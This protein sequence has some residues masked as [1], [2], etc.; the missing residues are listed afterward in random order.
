LRVLPACLAFLWTGVAHDVAASEL[1]IDWNAP[2]ECPSKADMVSRVER[3]LSDA[4]AQAA[5]TATANV[6]RTSGTYR[7]T[8]RIQSTAGSGERTLEN[9]NCEILADSIALV[10][11]LS[12]ADTLA[13]QARRLTL[14]LSAH[15]TA[16][17][18]PLPSL[19]LGGGAGLALEGFWAL[20]VELSGTYYAPQSST[21]E[22]TVV[23]ASFD[24]LRFGARACRLWSAG[25]FDLAPCLGAQLYRIAGNGFGGVR[26]SNGSAYVWGPALGVFARLRLY[27]IVAAVLAADATLPVSRQTF[28][29]TDLGPLHRPAALA[30]QLFI[31]PE[32]RF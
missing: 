30:L 19:A 1:A 27:S 22:Q 31:G 16:V 18:G 15:A 3:S 7:A 10:I 20:R 8:L 32:V 12:A 5:L 21:Y 29:Y 17:S 4:P 2:T 25:H 14:A 13:S 6:T 11:A 24:L 28:V 9:A 26:Y 23:G